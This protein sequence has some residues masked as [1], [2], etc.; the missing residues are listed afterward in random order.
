MNVTQKARNEAGQVGRNRMRA[1]KFLTVLIALLACTGPSFSQTSEK[2]VLLLN[3]YLYS[4]H[5]PFFLGKE[6]GYFLDEGI[7]LDIQE[8]RGSVPTVQAVAAGT[9]Q[10][11]YA[12]VASVIKAADKG[13]PVLTVGILLQKSPMAFISLSE[14][15]IRSVQDLRGKTLALTPGDSLSQVL[16]LV[17]NKAS[18]KESD[19]KVVAGDT[20]AKLNAVINGQADAMLG[21]LMDQNLKIEDATKKPASVLP[22]SDYGVNLAS[23]CIVIA[24]GTADAHPD[25]VR[26]F[27]K[28]AS[29]S[30][31]D[32]ERDPAAAVDAMLKAS[33]K[34][35]SRTDLIKGLE[36]TIPLY[37]TEATKGDPPFKENRAEFENSVAMLVQFGGVSSTTAQRMGELMDLGFLPN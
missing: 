35:G 9:A 33:P 6:R 25:L 37:H 3:F 30:V 7:D 32:A 1:P 17:L 8:G 24:K 31:A 27:M 20:R 26:R 23:S 4:E 34:A 19:F 22:F 14:K 36:L 28:A 16:P 10:F 13:A 12:D 11:G 5:A 29:R 15:G 21:Y 2:A 18:L